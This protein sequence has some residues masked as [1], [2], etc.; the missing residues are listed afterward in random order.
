LDARDCVLALGPVLDTVPTSGNTSRQ[1]AKILAVLNEPRLPVEFVG[2][3]VWS[4][5]GDTSLLKDIPKE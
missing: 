2:K 5:F 4:F 1:Q 3:I